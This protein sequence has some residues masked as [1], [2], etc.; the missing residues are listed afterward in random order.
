LNKHVA[1]TIATVAYDYIGSQGRSLLFNSANTIR[2]M[3]GYDS[4]DE[5]PRNAYMLLHAGKNI[6]SVASDIGSEIYRVLGIN[7]ANEIDRKRMQHSFGLMAIK[8]LIDAG[9]LEE[10]F[11]PLSVFNSLLST[12]MNISEDRPERVLFLQLKNRQGDQY[13][14]PDGVA[15]KALAAYAMS[16]VKE[17]VKQVLS[18]Q[19]EERL[20][21]TDPK[22][23]KIK[24]HLTNTKQVINDTAREALEKLNSRAFTFNE[25]NYDSFISLYNDPSTKEQLLSTLGYVHDIDNIHTYFKESV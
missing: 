9:Y 8:G 1:D 6:N 20:P 4:R 2:S 14:E 17:Q 22:K 18:L 12:P 23:I 25:A 3:L 21:I 5:L 11:I 10:K 19:T 16:G 13:I 7:T 15:E 24:E